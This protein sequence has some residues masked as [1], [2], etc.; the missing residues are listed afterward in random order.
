MPMGENHNVDGNQAALRQHELQK[1]ADRL[2]LMFTRGDLI[3]FIKDRAVEYR[4]EAK[5][6]LSA[7]GTCTTSMSTQHSLSRT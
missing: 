7:I 1:R 4:T 6:R 3:E 2:A 5:N